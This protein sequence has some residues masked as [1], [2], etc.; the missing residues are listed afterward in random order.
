M[1]PDFI[2]KTIFAGCSNAPRLESLSVSRLCKAAVSG[3]PVALHA[4]MQSPSEVPDFAG[5]GQ[6]RTGG[7]SDLWRAGVP[8]GNGK[9]SSWDAVPE[10]ESESEFSELENFVWGP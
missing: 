1:F 9:G 6:E 3:A 2:H 5:R 4:A 10:L 7:G 8:R